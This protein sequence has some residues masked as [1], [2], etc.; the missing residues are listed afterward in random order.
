MA[1]P[2]MFVARSRCVSFGP[3]GRGE[4]LTEQLEALN[5]SASVLARRLSVPA[6][7]VTEVLKVERSITGDTALRLGRF[8]GKTSEFWLSL[9]KLHDLRLAEQKAG[10]AIRHPPTLGSD[11][12]AGI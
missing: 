8:F 10:D 6:Y 12:H 9:Q 5:L 11:S 4:H 1:V 7:R 2:E 3:S